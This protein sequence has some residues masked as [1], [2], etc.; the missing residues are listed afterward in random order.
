MR[1]AENVLNMLRSEFAE[2]QKLLMRELR[3]AWRNNLL[4]RGWLVM[5]VVLL[6]FSIFSAYI[7]HLERLEEMRK[8]VWDRQ[9]QT[10]GLVHLYLQQKRFDEARKLLQKVIEED[11]QSEWGMRAQRMLEEW[12]AQR[13]EIEK[14]EQGE[15]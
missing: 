5:C 14:E 11:P 2:L 7:F 9:A 13:R 6:V 8:A 10:L 4:E 12:E 3:R 15:R 1:L